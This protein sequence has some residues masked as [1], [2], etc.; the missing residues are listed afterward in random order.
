[1]GSVVS[2]LR[3][4]ALFRDSF[5]AVFG[6]AL[7]KG[8]SFLGGILVARWLGSEVFGEYGVVKSNIVMIAIFSTLGMGYSATKFVADTGAGARWKLRV[9][10]RLVMEYTLVMSLAIALLVTVCSDVLADWLDCPDLGPIF[11]WTAPAIVFN[12]VTTAQ[13]GVLSGLKKYKLLARNTTL[14]GIYMFLASVAGAYF[15]QLNGALAALTSSYLVNMMLNL[16]EIRKAIE[17]EHAAPES[18]AAYIKETRGSLLAFSIP[19]ALQESLYSVTNWFSVAILVRMA[20][21]SEYGIYCAAVQWMVIISFVPGSLRNVALS[22]FASN[23]GDSEA[24]KKVLAQLSL[25]NLA[26]TVIPATVI[27]LASTLI[28]QLYGPTYVGVGVIIS[29]LS[30]TA[31]FSCQS[32]LLTQELMALDKNWLLF[33]SRLVRD[34]MMLGG[35]VLLIKLS[36]KGALSAS[37]S[38]LACHIIYLIILF[39]WHRRLSSRKTTEMPPALK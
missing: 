4:S 6:N 17:R 30:F 39:Y 29:L 14:T 11:R 32:N 15:F 37:V 16:I 22:Y 35:I 5:W 31:V 26:C 36:V 27:M 23:R 33:I 3:G 24:N 13:I 9:I 28:G 8:L 25:V 38:M 34:L 10:H 7:G 19:I 12:A 1:M 20:S 18:E 2:R 21:Y